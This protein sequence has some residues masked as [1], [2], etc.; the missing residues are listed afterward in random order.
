MFVRFKAWYGARFPRHSLRNSYVAG[1]GPATG[2][3]SA[4]YQ[5]SRG[6]PRSAATHFRRKVFITI[7]CVT[8]GSYGKV[9]RQAMTGII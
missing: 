8:Q 5:V 4:C 1:Y 3:E 9:T 6:Q 7:L 2:P